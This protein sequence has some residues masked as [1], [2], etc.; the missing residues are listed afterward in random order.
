MEKPN[1]SPI[2]ISCMRCFCSQNMDFEYHLSNCS[3]FTLIA[4]QPTLGTG[5]SPSVADICVISASTSCSSLTV[6][7]WPRSN[8][9][10]EIS[11]LSRMPSPLRS[12]LSKTRRTSIS[13]RASLT[14]YH[15][16]KSS[17]ASLSSLVSGIL[18]HNFDAVSSRI[19]SSDGGCQPSFCMNK[20]NS[21]S[22]M[23]SSPSWSISW[24]ASCR[25]HFISVTTAMPAVSVRLA[26]CVSSLTMPLRNLDGI[27][28][29]MLGLF[30]R[31]SSP[32]AVSRFSSVSGNT[33]RRAHFESNHFLTFSLTVM[34]PQ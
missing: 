31:F 7:R 16:R 11:S 19:S 15:R 34:K 33:A 9:N 21:A 13:M 29:L 17:K 10:C 4:W 12:S 23:R 3:N 28:R 30:C 26:C 20:L 8:S 18:F 24:K 14:M 1:S 25:L 5:S 27:F 6:G 22:S 32:R 2:S